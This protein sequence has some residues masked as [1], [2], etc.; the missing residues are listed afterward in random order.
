MLSFF[1]RFLSFDRLIGPMLVR[2]VYYVGLAVIT[3][4][5][6]G[7]LFAALMSIFTGN[8]P[9]GIVQLIMA[10]LV[11]AVGLLYWRFVCE[12]FMLAFRGYERLG[13]VR[14]LMRIAAG[15]APPSEADPNHPSF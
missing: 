15:Q 11:A 13:Q 10:P 4:G 7:V 8:F 14:D 2:L 3:F 9:Q 6:I 1:Q 5:A 12:L